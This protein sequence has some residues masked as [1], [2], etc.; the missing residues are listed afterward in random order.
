[1]NSIRIK[2]YYGEY[3]SVSVDDAVFEEWCNMRREEYNRRRRE[4]AHCARLSSE[5]I[6]LLCV[7]DDDPVFEEYKR[8]DEINRLYEAI[9]KLTPIQRRRIYMLLEDMSYTDIARAEGRVVSVI[10]RSIQKAIVN[11]KQLMSE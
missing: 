11:L 4:K 8:I 6:E 10:H 7:T 5:I 3:Q 9:K 1:M 2:N